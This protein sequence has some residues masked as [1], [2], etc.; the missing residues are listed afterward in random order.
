[1]TTLAELFAIARECKG[2]TQK[3]LG[4][5]SGVSFSEICRIES[6]QTRSPSFVIVIRLC[7]ALGVSLDRAAKSE[8]A[9]LDV[10]RKSGVWKP[11]LPDPME[12]S[13]P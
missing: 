7:D 2:W 8:R 13:S 1:M 6:G 12:G 9:R 4:Q 10:L 11:E 5:A 3:E